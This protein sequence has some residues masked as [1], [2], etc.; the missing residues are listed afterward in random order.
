[1]KRQLPALLCLTICAFVP[2]A[3]GGAPAR[4]AQPQEHPASAAQTEIQEA[5]AAY[6]AKRYEDALK[7]YRRANK[8]EKEKC[9]VCWSGIAQS[10]RRLQD[11]DAALK[12]TERCLETASEDGERAAAHIIRGDVY[13]A[14]PGSEKN[15]K[16]AEAEY[17]EAV[18][19]APKAAVCHFR[20]AVA[21]FRLSQDQEGL[22]ETQRC[23]D[24]DP[25][26][27]FA[28]EARQYL[29]KPDR[30]RY[31]FAPDFHI[32]T[33]RGENIQLEGLSGK[34]VVLDF[35]AT[36]CGPCRE[37]IGELKDL[38]K[39][40]P[41]DQMVLI[42]ISAD[43]D[44]RKWREFVSEKKMEW[45]QYWDEK[46]EIRQLF[47]VHAFPTYL[48]ID[49]EGAIRERLEGLDPR[50]SVVHRLKEALPAI[51]AAKPAR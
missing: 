46:G 25:D 30:A 7:A 32:V 18:Q 5:R 2:A 9:F 51:F 14:M 37:S 50:D 41:P 27:P 45:R 35:W 26:G 12:S 28:T 3:L 39:K 10:Q 33:L 21:L 1:M 20:L 29:A 13:S 47:H 44:E 23:L 42:S 16:A 43:T 40:Y 34:V 24:L 36:W 11:W 38:V 15:R 48:V 31:D 17:R 4:R 8:I 22:A 49:R 6:A 19:L